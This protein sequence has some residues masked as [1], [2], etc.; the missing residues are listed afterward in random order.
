MPAA[1]EPKAGAARQRDPVR[2]GAAHRIA[3]V[4]IGDAEPA[5]GD[6]ILLPDRGDADRLIGVDVLKRLDRE[7]GRHAA[8]AVIAPI[9]RRMIVEDTQPAHQQQ[10]DTKHID[11]MGDAHRDAVPVHDF[12]AGRRRRGAGTARLVA[13]GAAAGPGASSISSDMIEPA[14][15]P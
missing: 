2:K 12:A 6:E 15:A 9:E 3:V 11:P 8:V 10:D 1:S 5:G 13:A 4:I 14:A 7:H